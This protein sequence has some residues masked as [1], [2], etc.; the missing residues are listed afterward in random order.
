MPFIFTMLPG[1]ASDT[2]SVLTILAWRPRIEI[3]PGSKPAEGQRTQQ[4]EFTACLRK[5]GEQPQDILLGG[6]LENG[7]YPTLRM[8]FMQRVW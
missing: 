5:A 6:R 3:K 8:F 1:H 4:G 2:E 7:K